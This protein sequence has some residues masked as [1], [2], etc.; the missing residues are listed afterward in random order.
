[1]PAPAVCRDQYGNIV[2]ATYGDKAFRAEYD[3]DNNMIY[4]AFAVVG[5]LDEDL[6][7]QIKQLNYTSNNLI[8]ILW[9]EMNGKASKGYNFSW[10]DRASYTYS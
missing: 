1:M 9:P 5:S 2:Q 7:W 8:S 6:V 4:A 3:G 10:D